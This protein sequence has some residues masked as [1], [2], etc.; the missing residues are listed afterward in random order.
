MGKINQRCNNRVIIFRSRGIDP[1]VQKVASSLGESGYDVRLFVWDRKGDVK[2]DDGL[3]PYSLNAV[4]LPAPYDSPISPLLWPVWWMLEFIILV[5][6]KYSLIHACDFDTAVPAFI[7]SRVRGVPF[8]YTIYDYYS[9]NIPVD[10]P[11]I[12]K[13]ISTMEN[14]F[15]NRADCLFIVDKN[16]FEQIKE[17]KIRDFAVINNSP[18]D[19]SLQDTNEETNFILFYG[20]AL[21]KT[22]GIGLLIEV[23]KRLPDVQVIIAGSGPEEQNIREA[24]K[25][26]TNIQYL[27]QISHQKIIEYSSKAD[28]IVAMYD[29]SIK[30]NEYASPNKLFEA[31]MLS[32]PIITSDNP[33]LLKYIDEERCGIVIPYGDLDRLIDAITQLQNSPQIS[34]MYGRNGRLAY[35]TKYSWEIMKERLLEKYASHLSK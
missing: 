4:R 15:I 18:V 20:G 23:A 26:G 1:A 24:I 28:A 5:R 12:K 25:Q 30:N 7:A 14:F 31:M 3:L 33:A 35:E 16:R 29:P 11:F 32:K 6:N 19:V 9:A 34:K 2:T 8:F 22:R 17:C 13:I 21:L 10:K 27:G